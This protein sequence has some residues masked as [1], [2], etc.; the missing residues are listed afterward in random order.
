M[1]PKNVIPI[2][3]QQKLEVDYFGTLDNLRER[4]WFCSEVNKRIV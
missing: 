3:L 4:L 2:Q 1:L